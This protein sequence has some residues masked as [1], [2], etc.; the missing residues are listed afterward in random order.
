MAVP[1]FERPET[2]RDQVR[3]HLRVFRGAA[4]AVLLAAAF[5]VANNTLGHLARLWIRRK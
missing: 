2:L 3:D 5:K 1:K 4:K